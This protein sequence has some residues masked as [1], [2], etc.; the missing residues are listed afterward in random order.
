[1]YIDKKEEEE[2][3]AP[4]HARTNSMFTKDNYLSRH[5]HQKS[6]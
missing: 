5:D 6:T 4:K 1:M 2:L 3:E